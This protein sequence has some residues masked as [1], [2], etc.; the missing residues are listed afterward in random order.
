MKAKIGMVL[1]GLGV[2]LLFLGSMVLF[3]VRE[4][5]AAVVATFGR[6]VRTLEQP[7]LY[8]RWPWPVQKVYRMDRRW[9]TLEGPLEQT[10]TQDGKSL[11]VSLFAGWR[12]A[13]PLL[14][15]ERVGTPEEAERALTGLLSHARNAVLGRHRLAHLVS[16]RPEQLQFDRVEEDMLA[17]VGPEARARY[18]VEVAFVGIRRLQMPEAITA[19][20]FERM[21][22][23]RQELAER[24][25]AEGQA[26]AARIRAE[27]ESARER[28]LAEADAEA[29]R[30]RAEADAEAAEY[31]KVFEQDAELALFLRKLEVLEETLREKATVV[32]G[33][34]TQPFDLLQGESALPARAAGR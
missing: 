23:E 1:L 33:L 17:A 29:K 8:A 2:V 30:L 31:Y 10:L 15:L 32:L 3:T 14:F 12:V 22:A 26:E 24:Y 27:A 16:A 28:V 6:P 11:V 4:G 5:E 20:V 21:R 25:R 13:D 7:G 9:R 19:K 18:G 34:D